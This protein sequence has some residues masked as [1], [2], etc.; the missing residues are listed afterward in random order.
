MSYLDNILFCGGIDYR[1]WLFFTNIKKYLGNI[2]LG[3]QMWTE[4]NNR[5]FT[6]WKIWPCALG[7]SKIGLTTVTSLCVIVYLGFI[8]IDGAGNNH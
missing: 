3:D 7:Q 5:F 2:N 1:F 4:K 8:I 6:H